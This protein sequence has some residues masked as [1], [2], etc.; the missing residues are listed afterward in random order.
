VKRWHD[1]STL[2]AAAVP[3]LVSE[4]GDTG[5]TKK[6]AP[7]VFGDRARETRYTLEPL[8]DTCIKVQTE[9]S[10]PIRPPIS[11][12]AQRVSHI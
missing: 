10:V 7:T 3:I 11:T 6:A 5:E 9:S 1:R 12:P 8:R 2:G 4:S